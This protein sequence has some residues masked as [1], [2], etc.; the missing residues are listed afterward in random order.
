MSR[1]FRGAVSVFLVL[2]ACLPLLAIPG[3]STSPEYIGTLIRVMLA[4]VGL[5]VC[6]V[7]LARSGVTQR[8]IPN[9]FLVYIL[10]V[11]TLAYAAWTQGA[12]FDGFLGMRIDAMSVVGVGSALVYG[13][14]VWCI[15]PQLRLLGY[16]AL[17]A[18]ASMVLSAILVVVQGVFPHLLRLPFSSSDTIPLAGMTLLAALVVLRNARSVVW[19]VSG[20]SV[21]AAALTTLVVAHAS[22]L[23]WVGVGLV[24]GVYTARYAWTL[25]HQAVRS[26]GTHIEHLLG[27]ERI[28]GAQVVIALVFFVA[29]AMVSIPQLPERVA[30]HG[31]VR[32]SS[33]AAVAETRVLVDGAIEQ[34]SF[35]GS[36]FGNFAEQWFRAGFATGI[37]AVPPQYAASTLAGWTLGGGLVAGAIWVAGAVMFLVAGVRMRY[38]LRL[39]DRDWYMVAHAS[40]LAAAWGVY[41]ASVLV[42]G[43]VSLAVMFMSMGVFCVAYRHLMREGIGEYVIPAR[44]MF[45]KVLGFA[46]IVLAGTVMLLVVRHAQGVL[47][48]STVVFEHAREKAEHMQYMLES[49]E[50]TAALIE[51]MRDGTSYMDTVCAQ[52]PTHLTL[53]EQCMS[54]FTILGSVGIEGSYGRAAEHARVIA[55]TMPQVAVYQIHYAELL[56]L[57]GRADDAYRILDQEGVRG[58][59]EALRVHVN[60]LLAQQRFDEVETLLRSTET[61]RSSM[62]GQLVSSALLMRRG[63]FREAGSALDQFIARFP[64]VPE[65]YVYRAHVYR[66]L[67][68]EA[69]ARTIVLQGVS[70]VRTADVPALHAALAAFAPAGTI[71]GSSTVPIGGF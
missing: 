17:C 70:A 61:F 41:S 11:F 33:G 4:G 23:V 47:L 42:V 6:G 2:C 66:A 60:G 26:G 24:T 1:L 62:Y 9:V 68:D 25:L 57:A 20:V 16:G 37:P 36:G 69:S 30:L 28:H 3:L 54:W 59:E 21:V 10:F 40:W 14:L 38:F 51:E 31:V 5:G 34:A 29:L 35:F 8:A 45:R 15:Q 48:L 67:G 71:M 50:D 27:R 56:V 63:A 53:R 49:A 46:S 22:N 12:G 65:G 18:G 64:A 19:Y 32:E 52:Y 13:L 43:T 44:F 58:T 39:Y 7:V 55:D